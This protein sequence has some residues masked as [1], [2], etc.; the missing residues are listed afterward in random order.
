MKYVPLF[1]F[2]LV[3]LLFCQCKKQ[4]ESVLISDL[5][6]FVLQ[7]E[8]EGYKRPCSQNINCA[9][10]EYTTRK[11]IRVN[12]HFI[13]SPE[14]N[15]T[16]PLAEGREYLK[17][18]IA[19]AN[20]RLGKNQK[21]FLPVGND[22]PVLDPGF[23]YKIV[24]VEEGDD[25]FYYHI[26]SLHYFFINKGKN[27]NNYS[28]DVI[29]KYAVAA[30]SILNIFVISHPQDSLSSKT[31]KA[32]GAGVALGTSLKITGLY[33]RRDD[34]PWSWGTLLNHE[35][36]HVL[37]LAHA[38]GSDGCDD[39][40]VHANCWDRH[41]KRGSTGGPC[42][43]GYS[44]NVMD[45]NNQQ[46]AYTPCQL[47]KIH[48]SFHLMN[49]KTRGLIYDAWCDLDTTESI[50]I[51]GKVEWLCARD[52]NKNIVIAK[53]GELHLHCRLGMA[54]GSRIK[55]SE[56]G[57][58]HI[59]SH[60][61]INNACGETWEGIELADIKNVAKMLFVYGQGRIT[62]VKRQLADKNPQL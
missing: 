11:T 19:N 28:R 53:G 12:L 40:P 62:E 46:M 45:Y 14:Q 34:P 18:V 55:V 17:K 44:N 22:T 27:R 57:Q 30:D 15:A 26:D 51:D 3:T 25:G 52:I 23:R 10:D 41:A 1:L 33:S 37:G 29:K 36:G 2:S 47:G 38:W 6:G 48:K 59:H 8:V 43:E 4:K 21:M 58:L 42:G 39:T 32:H 20:K 13:D 60:A 50:M 56:G 9:P 5:N 54:S 49:S 61:R 24:G 31:Y 16:W 7:E 35:I